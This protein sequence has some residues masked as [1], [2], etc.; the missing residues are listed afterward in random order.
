MLIACY[1]PLT[2]PHRFITQFNQNQLASIFKMRCSINIFPPFIFCCLPRNLVLAGICFFFRMLH[3]FSYNNSEYW[4]KWIIYK[5]VYVEAPERFVRI[6]ENWNGN[7]TCT[8]IKY[9]INQSMQ[10]LFAFSI[11]SIYAIKL[12]LEWEFFILPL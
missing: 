10:F 6:V 7:E 1:S 2:A 3:M 8:F 12:Q 11:Y 9:Q 5:T 4:I